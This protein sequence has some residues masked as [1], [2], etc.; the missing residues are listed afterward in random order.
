[1]LVAATLRG[2][3]TVW[4]VLALTV[5]GSTFVSPATALGAD[6]QVEPRRVELVLAMGPGFSAT[7]SHR[8]LEATKRLPVEDVRIR[9]A[10]QG[11]RPSIASEESGPAT[12]VRVTGILTGRQRLILPDKQF[13]IGE[14]G[15]FAAWLRRLAAEGPENLAAERVAFGLTEE[16]LRTVRQTL[17]VP[18]PSR[19]QGQTISHVLRE[20]KGITKAEWIVPR[21]IESRWSDTTLVASELQG[22]SVG[23]C[24]AV[25]LRSHHLMLVPTISAE[26]TVRL[27][28]AESRAGEVGWPVGWPPDERPNVLV[29]KILE[30]VEIGID[31]ATLQESL[32]VLQQRLAVPF[33]RDESQLRRLQVVPS[34]VTVQLAS[35]KIIY[36][37]A[38][39]RILFPSRLKAELRVDDGRRPFLWITAIQPEAGKSKRTP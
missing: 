8:W 16:Q 34:D 23:T 35:G 19:T 38:L 39:D 28:I 15:E 12:T 27:T 26:R 31:G 11:E 36:K 7:D 4:T 21:T 10:R 29:P 1:M 22:L 17:A 14:M 13:G 2:V 25:A 6:P 37:K 24:L 20:A 5:A 30:F 33:I 3:L 18:C 32:D 9:V